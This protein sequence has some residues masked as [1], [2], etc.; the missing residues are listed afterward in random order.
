MYTQLALAKRLD[1]INSFIQIT[2]INEKYSLQYS[3]IKEVTK[4]A[5]GE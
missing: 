4:K 2:S 1:V 5:Q 3:T